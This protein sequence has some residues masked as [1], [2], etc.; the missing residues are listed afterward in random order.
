MYI[1]FKISWLTG[2]VIQLRHDRVAGFGEAQGTFH[3]SNGSNVLI[4]TSVG[5]MERRIPVD[6]GSEPGAGIA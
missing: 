6:A 5:Q 3:F 1:S 2:P 4:T